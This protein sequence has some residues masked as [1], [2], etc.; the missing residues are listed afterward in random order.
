MNKTIVLIENF[1]SDPSDI[2]ICL[3]DKMIEIILKEIENKD[4]CKEGEI[5]DA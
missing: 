3:L 2:K 4:S 1:K 5:I